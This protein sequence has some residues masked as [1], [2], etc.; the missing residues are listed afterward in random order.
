VQSLED[1]MGLFFGVSRGWWQ[2]AVKQFDCRVSSPA[3]DTPD[4]RCS[5]QSWS[6]STDL[7]TRTRALGQNDRF[8]CLIIR[9]NPWWRWRLHFCHQSSFKFNLGHN[10]ALL[11]GPSANPDLLPSLPSNLFVLFLGIS[12]GAG[13]GRW[14]VYEG[15][16]R[17]ISAESVAN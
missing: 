9:D 1:L 5:H 10:R 13:F 15:V 4:G 17:C 16:C 14:W 6:R 2:L 11:L 8:A 3:R 12:S 7:T